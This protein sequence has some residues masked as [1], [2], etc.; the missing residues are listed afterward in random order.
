M[1]Q[2][3]RER[4]ALAAAQGNLEKPLQESKKLRERLD[5]L[6]RETQLLANRGNKSALLVVDELRKRGITINPESKAVSAP[7]G[8][9]P[10][11]PGVAPTPETP[12]APG[13]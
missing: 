5:T 12:P 2:L 4:D 10:R 8:S 11:V 13:K 7:P 9:S 1:T 6:A 3:M